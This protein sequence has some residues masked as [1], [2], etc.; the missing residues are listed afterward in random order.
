M[1]AAIETFDL[2]KSYGT[3]RALVG[4]GLR[5]EANQ[6]FGFLG[7]NGAGKTTTIRL[8]LALQRPTSGRASVF[9]L[10]AQRDTVEIHRRIG[11]LP[12]TCPSTPE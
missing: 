7:P 5:V 9:G 6:C 10:N 12:G 3:T 1:T 8:L 11:Y 2:A 4:L